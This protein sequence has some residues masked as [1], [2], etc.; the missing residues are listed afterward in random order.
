MWIKTVMDKMWQKFH[1]R[2][3]DSKRSY[4]R[5]KG[6]V[7]GDGTRLNCNTNAFGTEPYLIRVGEDCLFAEGVRLITHDGG[8]KVLNALGYFQGERYDRMG[9]IAIGNNVYLGTD[10]M[11]MPDVRIGDN[12]IIGAR[13]V[14]THDIPANSVAVGIPAKVIKNIDEY[15]QG[16]LERAVFYP[17][18]GMPA[19]EKRRYLEENV[20]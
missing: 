15:Y 3:W 11:V 6:A 14:V 5:G 20:K 7:I 12:C 8:V 9:R 13:A 19:D 4:L 18:V 16:G 2:S 17:S 1:N 10:A